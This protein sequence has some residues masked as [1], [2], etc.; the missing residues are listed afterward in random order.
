MRA[1][2]IN[3]EARSI[4]SEFEK[5][6]AGFEEI[7]RLEPK[8]IDHRRRA[9]PLLRYAR[10]H[11]KLMRFIVHSPCDMMDAA[12]APRTASGHRRFPKINIS[13]GFSVNDT[14]T[15]PAVFRASMG[16]AQRAREKRSGDD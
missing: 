15:M 9:R 12:R 13:A 6:A 11:L 1:V 16:E 2:F 3:G 14:V 8:T 7:N 5:N 4:C 10:A